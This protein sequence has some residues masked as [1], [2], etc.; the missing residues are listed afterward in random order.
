[1]KS[2]KKKIIIFGAG[3]FGKLAL[4]YYGSEDVELFV[5][6]NTEKAGKEYC[7][8][9]IIS[10]EGF[11][12]I[13]DKYRIVIAVNSYEPIVKQ[14]GEHRISKFL[15][16]SPKFIRALERAKKGC[17]KIR[18]TVC[19]LGIDEFTYLLLNDMHQNNMKSVKI[20]LTEVENSNWIGQEFEGH[21]VEQVE[22]VAGLA[23]AIVI[24][25]QD[26]AFALQVHAENLKES[27]PVINPFLQKKYYETG[28]IIFNQYGNSAVDVTEEEWNG[29]NRRNKAIEAIGEY[30]KELSKH[31]PL[32]EHVEIETVNRCNGICDFCPVS[33]GHDIREKA[34]MDETLFRSIIDQLAQMDYSGRLATFSNNEPFLDKRIIAFNQYARERL[35]KARMHLFTNGTLLTLDKFIEIMKYL[36]ELI[37]D[38][39]AQDLKLIKNSEII[40]DYCEEHPELKEKVTIVL[41]KP[42]EILTSRGGDAPN[43]ID[44][45]SYPDASCVLPFKQLIIRPD[46]KVSLCCNDPYGRNTLGD[47]TKQTIMEVWEGSEFNKIRKKLL[48][49]RK[50]VE[51][52]RK[53]DTF[54]VY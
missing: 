17:Q 16:F 30:A 41:R 9:S 43:R 5:D 53:C 2:V 14:L 26:R 33:A 13:A 52:C 40:K 42:H 25:A 7:G 48:I 22:D 24:S 15:I 6:N 32:F 1:M 38:N 34:V 8:K 21:K 20:I 45:P 31:S 49:G 12:E 27:I 18:G 39:Y 36:D 37:I 4:E 23:E 11:L 51:H 19:L 10:F 44:M 3:N 50:E 29:F 47:L 46:G 35:P 54:I 28:D